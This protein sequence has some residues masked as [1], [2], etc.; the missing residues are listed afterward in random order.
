[1]AEQGITI[2][3]QPEDI[4]NLLAQAVLNSSIG[5]QINEAISKLKQ[6]YKTSNIVDEAVKGAVVRAANDIAEKIIAE[7]RPKIEELVRAGVTDK[8]LENIV[9]KLINQFMTAS[10]Y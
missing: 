2:N 8:V 10:R 4:N 3:V 9:G 7:Q 5:K 1:M 6:D